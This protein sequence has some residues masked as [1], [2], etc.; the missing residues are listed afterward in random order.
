MRIVVLDGFALNPGDNPWDKVA[1]L[2]QLSV[3]D[4]TAPDQVLERAKD[5]DVL[6]T[7]K[8]VLSREILAQLPN[9]KFVSV[10]ATGYNIVDTA[11]AAELGIPVSNVP[12][13]STNSVAQL[14][15]ALI[16]ELCHGTAR[17]SDS[18]HSGGWVQAKDY[19]YWV[20]P[21]MELKDKVIGII[22]MGAIGQKVGEI[23]SAFG[24]KVLAYNPHRRELNVPYSFTYVTLEELY[25]NSDFI[26]LHCPMKGD[27]AEM[28]NRAAIEQMKPSAF[29]INTARGQ[30]ICEADLA[31]ALNCGRIAG[32]ALDVLSC[33]PPKAD[34]PLLNAKNALITPH[35]AW[36]TAEARKRLMQVTADNIRAFQCGTPIN[37]VNQ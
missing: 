25:A 22:G 27:N 37:V 7:N 5:A 3:Y 21:L 29:L 30:L 23:A 15:F 6:L 9:L 13:Y 1:E 19:S 24:M 8:T 14:T 35:I 28:I 18:V 12:A 33:E 36:A 4:R 10:L 17:H 26:T 11:A 20:Q 16:L 34:N 32:A 2:G 31:D